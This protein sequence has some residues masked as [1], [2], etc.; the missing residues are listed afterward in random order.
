MSQKKQLTATC[1]SED[2]TGVKSQPVKNKGGRPSKYLKKFVRDAKF[3]CALGA[4]DVQLAEYFCVSHETLNTWKEKF[5]EFL[6]ALKD[7]KDKSDSE[8][9]VSL[10]RRA[11]GYSHADIDIRT[12]S[13]GDGC[14]QIVQTPIIKHYPPD[15]TSM[16]FWLKNRQKEK[17][18]DKHDVVHQNPDGTNIA[19]LVAIELSK[20]DVKE[21]A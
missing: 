6:A 20:N 3:L 10:F 14:S 5:P 7:S 19:L 21:I 12:V 17:W 16:I 1:S 4:T 9:E 18:R 8:V 11:M 15:P 2:Y 13:I